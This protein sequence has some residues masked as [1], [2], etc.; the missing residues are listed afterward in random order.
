MGRGSKEFEH[1]KLNAELIIGEGFM[2]TFPEIIRT[3]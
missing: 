2:P 3:F 1:V